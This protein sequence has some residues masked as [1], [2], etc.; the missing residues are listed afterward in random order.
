M[1]GYHQTF[2]LSNDVQPIYIEEAAMMFD[3]DLR[4]LVEY[5]F[6][7]GGPFFDYLQLM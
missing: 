1:H 2:I 7:G 4:G 6:V 5:I 3:K